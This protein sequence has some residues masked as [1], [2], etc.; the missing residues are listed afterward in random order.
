MCILNNTI[1]NAFNNPHFLVVI[2]DASI[3]NNVTTP[4][5]YIYSYNRLVTKTV[6]Y[7]VNITT[8]EA[9][10]YKMRVWTDFRVRI[11]GQK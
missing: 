10:Y 4:I 1:I 3:R 2:A 11:R 9:K 5:A 6:H 8:I 7:A